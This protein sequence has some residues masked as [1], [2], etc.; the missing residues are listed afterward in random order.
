M[1]MAEMN[2][3]RAEKPV[4]MNLSNRITYPND[5]TCFFHVFSAA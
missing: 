5:S 3:E 2:L 1:E 4:N